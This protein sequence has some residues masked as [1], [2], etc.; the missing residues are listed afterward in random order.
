MLSL[1]DIASP[2]QLLEIMSTTPENESQTDSSQNEK[3]S[4]YENLKKK[5]ASLSQNEKKSSYE[6]LKKK[7][8]L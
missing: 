2:P 7:P 8:L 3:K 1:D 6:N 5:A 4:S